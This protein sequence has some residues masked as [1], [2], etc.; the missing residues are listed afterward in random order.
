MTTVYATRSQLLDRCNLLRL[1]QLAVP[2]GVAMPDVTDVRAALLGDTGLSVDTATAAVLTE[3]VLAVDTALEDG[4]DLMRSYQVPAMEQ[5]VPPVLVRINCQ[6]AMHYLAERAGM[7]ADSDSSNYNALIKLL[8][9][10]ASG[11]VSLTPGAEPAPDAAPSADVARITS[12]RSRYGLC[13][14]P[15]PDSEVCL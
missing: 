8:A 10:H 3:A 6:L 15:D 5:P 11:E 13:S 12:G 9:K 7:L 2:T 1:A 14:D 4:A